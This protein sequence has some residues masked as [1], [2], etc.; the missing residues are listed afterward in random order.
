MGKDASKVTHF[1]WYA[2][3]T[4]PKGY[5][6]E[7]ISGTF[8]CKGMNAGINIPSG[9]TLTT[10]WGKSASAYVGSD[11]VP[12]L[13][14]RVRVTFYS[15]AEKQV[16]EAEFDLP[17]DDMLAKFQQQLRDAPDKRNYSHF[18]LG[19][20]PGGAVSVWIGGP[21][22]IEVFFGQAKKIEKTPSATFDLPF[23]SKEQSDD[24]AYGALVDSV[25][26]EQLAHIKAHGVP[27]GTWARYRNLYKWLPVYKS[28]KPVTDIEMSVDYLNGES[29]WTPTHFNDELAN[30]PKPLP[31]HLEFSAQATKEDN[32][33]YIIDFEPVE[34]MEA[35]EK[36]GAN[37][38]KVFIEFDAQV[39]V[40]NMRIRVYNDV[41]PKDD[42]TPKEFIELKKFKVDP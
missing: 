12:P 24:Y 19:V 36:L 13:P 11:E 33:F 26:P 3:A 28:G 18:I 14:D 29:W 34:L 2:V 16:Y 41:E 22:V 1:K 20:A 9:G 32:P 39:P 10:G 38:E 31:L 17:Y 15:Y 6:M 40:T 4:A 8:F 21:K 30:T 23:Q 25:T 7:I 5:P 27:I 35:F 42:K 37:G